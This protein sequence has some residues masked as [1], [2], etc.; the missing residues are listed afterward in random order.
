VVFVLFRTQNALLTTR[1]LS[2]QLIQ[3]I[4]L[5]RCR[6]CIVDLVGVVGIRRSSQSRRGRPCNPIDP[7]RLLMR[8]LVL[9]SQLAQSALTRAWSGCFT[10]ERSGAMH[11]CNL[12]S[13][14]FETPTVLHLLLGLVSNNL[15]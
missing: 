5:A 14:P 1:L 10:Y 15:R 13:S 11:D 3:L 8:M 9:L 2:G 7:L 6:R 12:V 4:H